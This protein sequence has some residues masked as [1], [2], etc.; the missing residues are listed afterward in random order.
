M[1]KAALWIRPTLAEM[2]RCW[3]CWDKS[4]GFFFFFPSR[5]TTDRFIHIIIVM[6][7]LEKGLN[8]GRHL[9]A[10]GF[11]L[12]NITSRV[13]RD[14]WSRRLWQEVDRDRGSVTALEAHNWSLPVAGLTTDTLSASWQPNWIH[15]LLTWPLDH[16][17]NT[18][19][20]THSPC[21]NTEPLCR[22]LLCPHS[23]F[24]QTRSLTARGKWHE[25]TRGID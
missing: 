12:E 22:C 19:L 23:M 5:N 9:Q 24:Y 3:I 6:T 25:E 11:P 8:A 1:L 15:T 17:S 20:D 10:A 7:S 13:R 2:K 4:A 14:S 16:R 21:L 18:H